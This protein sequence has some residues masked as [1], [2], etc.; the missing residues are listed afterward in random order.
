MGKRN[1][2][3]ARARDSAR[4]NSTAESGA[5]LIIRISYVYVFDIAIGNNIFLGTVACSRFRRRKCN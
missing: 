2:D 3:G 4:G 5:D 1:G